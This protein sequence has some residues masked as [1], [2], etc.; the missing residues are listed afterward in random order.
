MTFSSGGFGLPGLVSTRWDQL[1]LANGTVVSDPRD[2]ARIVG[3]D[4][5][6]AVCEAADEAR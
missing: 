1:V 6:T 2:L 3:N 4:S 5:P